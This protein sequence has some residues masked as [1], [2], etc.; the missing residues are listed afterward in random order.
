MLGNESLLKFPSL[1]AKPCICFQNL[2]FHSFFC[3]NVISIFLCVV[4]AYRND[5]DDAVE[6]NKI[7]LQEWLLKFFI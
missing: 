1:N 2:L 7:L 4:G 5:S 6:E 3:R